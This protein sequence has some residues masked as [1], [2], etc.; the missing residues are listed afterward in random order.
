M[1][2]QTCAD[3]DRHRRARRR[4]P[5][6]PAR[7]PAGRHLRLRQGLRQA[8]GAKARRRRPPTPTSPT[9][10]GALA[11]SSST[12]SSGTSTSSTTCTRAT[13]RG[14]RSPSKQTLH[15]Q[16]LA[17]R[18][19]RNDPLPARRRRA[20]RLGR[21][22]GGEGRDAPDRLP[23]GRLAR[24]LLRLDRLRRERRRTA[25]ASAATTPA[26]RC[27]KSG[28][29]PVAI[30]TFP[31]T[32]GPLQ[33]AHLLRPLG[34]EG[35]GLQQRADRAADQEAVARTV[36]LDGKTALDQPAVPG[37]SFAGPAVTG[38]FCGAVATVSDVINLESRSR[39]AAIAMIAGVGAA[40]APLRRR[41]QVG[42]GRPDASCAG[43]APLARSCERRDSSTAGTGGRWCR[44]A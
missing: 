25:P 14:C 3:R 17:D 34:R 37:G 6:R 13:G 21:R 44:S 18:P 20:G 43:D 41:H 40:A 4:V 24:D 2:G 19:E 1:T 30:P 35:G 39:P 11:S 23:G 26:S 42:P 36:H 7:R 33:V 15:A 32:T 28:L 27:A 31:T 9:R 22:Q 10:S 5:P 12:G 29:Q 38:A 8:E 16:A